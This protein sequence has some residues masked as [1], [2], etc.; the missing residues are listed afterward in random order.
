MAENGVSEQESLTINQEKF[1][2]ALLAGAQLTV[3]ASSSH[4]SYRTAQRWWK[5]PHV[6]AAYKA[7]QRQLFDQAL[8]GL[9]QKVDKA[10]ETLDRNMTGEEVSASTQVR[11]AQ[12]V[13]EQ[14]IAVHKMSELEARLAEL[15]ARLVSDE[16][17]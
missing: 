12:I 5:L 2:E 16:Q 13:L 3:A 10:I 7:A 9:M 6:Q 4:I 17:P 11:A 15:E 8:T 1:I 14:A